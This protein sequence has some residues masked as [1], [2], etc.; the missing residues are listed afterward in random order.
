MPDDHWEHELGNKQQRWI[1]YKNLS[2]NV[3]E[4]RDSFI[5]FIHLRT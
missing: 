3:K 4:Q 2:I 5:K 1:T